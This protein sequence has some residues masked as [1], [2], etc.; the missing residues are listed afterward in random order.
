MK[1][2]KKL[3]VVFTVSALCLGFSACSD[4]DEND[5]PVVPGSTVSE[6][7]PEG[8]PTSFDGNT[9]TK[10]SQGQVVKI[11]DNDGTEVTFE[12]VTSRADVKAY[13]V[14][15]TLYEDGKK[16]CDFKIR[17]NNRGFA[18][19]ALQTSIDSY[20]NSTYTDEWYFSY[21]GDGRLTQLKRSEGADEGLFEVDD[22]IY[23]GGNIIRVNH[24]DGESDS[25]NDI[26]EIA[27]DSTPVVNKGGIMLFDECFG[28]DM[29]EFA[30]AYYAGLLGKAT[31]NLPA[32][33]TYS[34]DEYYT[35]A[36]TLNNA[37]LPTLLKTTEHYGSSSYDDEITFNW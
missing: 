30:V 2:F 17:L 35:F 9:I 21:N 28:I 14:L 12:Y 3:A 37:G 32:K 13:D 8:L 29:D 7:F 26:A 11:S 6:V 16:D 24:T 25:E 10:N 15:M 4:D 22:I 31:K 27:Y 23:A 34:A 33:R 36:W 1:A 18:E 19:Y 20:D 5:G